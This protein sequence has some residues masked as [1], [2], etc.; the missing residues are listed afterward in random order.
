[1]DSSISKYIN[2]D[3]YVIVKNN[4]ILYHGEDRLSFI[5]LV[6]DNDKNN[7]YCFANRKPIHIEKV[8]K[9]GK[10]NIKKLSD[11]SSSKA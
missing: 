11:S 10:N 9:Y 3:K 2:N 4:K 5:N 1:M 7:M 6:C 8:A